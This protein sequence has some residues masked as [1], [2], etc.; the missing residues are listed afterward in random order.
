MVGNETTSVILSAL[1]YDQKGLMT[2]QTYGNNDY[3][4]FAYDSLDRLSEKSYND[5]NNNIVAKKQY[6]YGNDGNISVTVDFASNSYTRYNYDLSGRTASIREYSGTDVSSNIPISYT[7]YKYADKTNYLTNVKHFSPIG[8]QNIAYKYGNVNNGEM[9]DQVYSVSWNGVEKVTNK[10]DSLSRLSKRTV[11]GLAT[12]YT[13]KD[14]EG[15]Q[16]TTLVESINTGGISYVYDYDEVNNIKSVTVGNKKTT[17]EY[18]ELNQLTR[19]NDPFENVTHVYTYNN[20]NIVYDLVYEYS[21]GVLPSYPLSTTQYLY[22]NATWSDILTGIKKS[23]FDNGVEIIDD[24]YS[25]SSDTIGNITNLN[26]SEYSWLGRQLQSVSNSDNSKTTYSY[27]AD[28]QR[29][30]KA[31]NSANGDEY[32]YRYYYNGDILAGYRLVITNADGSSTTH[33]VAFMYDENGEAFGF[34][35]NGND[36]YYVRNAQNDVVR[37]VDSANKTVVSYQYD[38]W[39]KLLSCEDTSEND[40]VSFINP[41]TYRGYYYDSDTGFYYVFSRYY[42]SELFRFINADGELSQIGGDILGYNLFTYCFNNPVNMNDPSGEWPKW[43]SG[44]LKVVSGAAQMVAGVALGTFTSWT[45]IGAVVAGFLILNGAATI[46]QGTGQIVNN[47]TKS[48]MLREDNIVRTG[49]QNVGRAFGGDNGAKV[50]GNVYDVAVIAAN[51]YACKISLENSMPKIID[52]KVFSVN[53]GYGFKVGKNIE[54]FYRNPNAA[55]GLGGTIFS[56][57]GPLGK[58]RIDWDPAHGFHCHPPGH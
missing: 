24:R 7:E 53:D 33:N 22:E 55:G 23:H 21:V 3:I 50:A 9:P 12:N 48:K 36:Y 52:S 31:V 44:A 26:G 42:D 47:F 25:I 8:T 32:N 28:G 56:Y 6:L 15:N 58:F 49:V 39:G 2:K 27:N 46:A 35:Y 43:L 45:G 1:E 57:K 38:S 11:N 40:I 41:Y 30:A 20:G 10:F 16:T 13:Y 4:S 51:I 54:M 5:R 18:D 29:I 19:V 37:I 14:L 17:Y 34:N